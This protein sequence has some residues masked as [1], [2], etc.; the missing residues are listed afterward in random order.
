MKEGDILIATEQVIC[1]SSP[2]DYIINK[3]EK[4]TVVGFMHGNPTIKLGK[5]HKTGY[6][7][8]PDAHVVLDEARAKKFKE[9]VEG[10]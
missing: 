4:V 3:G 5:K 7:H 10:I 2:Q 8:L 9:E 6:P 1:K